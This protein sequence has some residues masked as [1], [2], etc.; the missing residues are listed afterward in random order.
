MTA[1]P[2]ALSI[3][4]AANVAAAVIAL[5]PARGEAQP[6]YF[7][8]RPAGR[9]TY[10]VEGER[11]TAQWVALGSLAGAATVA[12]AVGVAFTLR[13]QDAAS[14]V[15]AFAGEPTN[16]VY[17]EAVDARRR[18]AERASVVAGIAY[19]AGG[20]LLAAV[21]ITYIVTEPDDELRTY[22]SGGVSRGAKPLFVPV[23]GGAVV[24][25][26]WTF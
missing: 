7:N 1:R 9:P 20:G 4:V 14:D 10:R 2:A 25:G 21:V 17:T 15:E 13:Y 16:L 22:G 18:D 23:A 8:S 11:S 24:G 26:R 3:R 12:G 6:D 19:G 5:A